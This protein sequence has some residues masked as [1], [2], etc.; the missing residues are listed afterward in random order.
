[1]GP[2]GGSVHGMTLGR[3]GRTHTHTHTI[4]CN[5]TQCKNQVDAGAIRLCK[6]HTYSTGRGGAGGA[7]AEILYR[8]QCKQLSALWEGLVRPKERLLCTKCPSNTVFLPKAHRQG[9]RWQH[10]DRERSLRGS[11]EPGGFG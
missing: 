7:M 9:E 2:R 8:S 4:E 3:M 11:S 5:R 10:R 6:A 1:M